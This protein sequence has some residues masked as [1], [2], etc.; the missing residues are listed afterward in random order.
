MDKENKCPYGIQ[1]EDVNEE[2]CFNMIEYRGCGGVCNYEFLWDSQRQIMEETLLDRL[3]FKRY[4]EKTTKKKTIDNKIEIATSYFK[5]LYINDI[6]SI[7]IGHHSHSIEDI[8]KLIFKNNII[9]ENIDSIYNGFNSNLFKI[10]NNIFYINK[11]TYDEMGEIILDLS[12]YFKS[13]I[14]SL[15]I[16][17]SKDKQKEG[18]LL[19]IKTNWFWI[20]ST[21]VLSSQEEIEEEQLKLSSK[22]QESRNFFKIVEFFDTNWDL[23]KEKKDSTFQDLVFDLL[24]HRSSKVEIEP[25]GKSN[26]ADRGRDHIYVETID[27]FDGKKEIKWLI[28]C[29][30]SNK[31]ISPSSISGWVERVIEH[32]LDGYWLI[33]NNDISPGLYDQFKDIESN[34]GYNIKTK[35]WE[36]LHIE[37][38]INV[39]PSLYAKYF[40]GNKISEELIITVGTNILGTGL[41][42]SIIIPLSEIN[43][44]DLKRDLE[45]IKGKNILNLASLPPNLAEKV[46]EYIK[47]NSGDMPK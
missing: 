40:I 3:N 28:Q 13:K 7:I 37:S 11:D 8:N 46:K 33:T 5:D 2:S 27:T 42:H 10:S 34:Q 31:S 26:A 35:Y 1:L 30:Y 14:N 21:G 47:K 24:Y 43:Y 16:G 15:R 20:I 22:V 41:Q 39:Y 29:K 18:R 9:F 17:A 25:I 6:K 23:L 12:F 44:E 4:G 19:Y 38:L 45:K 32:H 36:R